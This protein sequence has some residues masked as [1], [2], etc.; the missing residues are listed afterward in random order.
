LFGAVANAHNTFLGIWFNQGFI[1]LGCVLFILGRTVWLARD[2]CSTANPADRALLIGASV[3]LMAASI[4]A[5]FVDVWAPWQFLWMLVALTA[6][7]AISVRAE[8][9]VAVPLTVARTVHAGPVVETAAD[10]WGWRA[11]P[12]VRRST[13]AG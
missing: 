8:R 13:G 12:T 7:L 11:R 4:G 5:F 6:R 2:A 10:P 1:G 3:G 9:P